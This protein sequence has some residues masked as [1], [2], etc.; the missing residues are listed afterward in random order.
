MVAMDTCPCQKGLKCVPDGSGAVIV[1]Q[2]RADKTQCY[3]S[4][5]LQRVL[6]NSMIDRY[7]DR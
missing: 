1:P 5:V 6:V 4:L 7:I 3:V 2:G